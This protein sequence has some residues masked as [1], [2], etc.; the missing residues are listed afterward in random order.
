VILAT[1][2]MTACAVASVPFE[3]RWDGD[4][5][6]MWRVTAPN[7][8]TMYLFGSIHAGIYEYYPLPDFVMDAFNR[9]DYLAVEFNISARPGVAEQNAAQALWTY[10]DGR[11]VVDDIGQDLFERASAVLT[12]NRRGHLILMLTDHLPIVWSQV[13]LQIAMMRADASTNWGID[14]YFI[15]QANSRNI[16]VLELES[17][18]SQT[19]MLAGL[20]MPLQIAM[21][22]GSLDIDE[23]T[24]GLSMMLEHWARGDVQW[25]LEL[26]QHD[27]ELLGDELYE[28]Y[29]Y[30]MMI[31]R[32]IAM[33]ARL[34]QHMA[35]GRK[36]FAV[37][38][39]YHFLG[40]GSIVDLLRQAGYDVVQVTPHMLDL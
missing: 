19:E 18:M 9:S 12:E 31:S 4:V 25:F 15:R 3:E 13:M 40:D 2:F 11:T 30:A 29:N 36:V 5:P 23:M 24:D 35:E 37:A 38:G 16:E 22:E 34:R 20:S 6:L 1:F 39:L 33:T 10:T 7:G 8:Q 14:I 17:F 28:E 32:D 21:L 26:E 27:A